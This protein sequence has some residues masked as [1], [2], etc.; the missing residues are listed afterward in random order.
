MNKIKIM[1]NFDFLIAMWFE[2]DELL[3]RN[4]HCFKNLLLL[5]LFQRH[6]CSASAPKTS[7]RLL[8]QIGGIHLNFESILV[9]KRLC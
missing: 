8:Q 3:W 2:S 7:G 5:Y 4:I 1:N 6:T 9:T